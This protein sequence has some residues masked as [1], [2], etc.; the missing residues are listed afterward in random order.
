[1]LA[2][3][4]KDVLH[5]IAQAGRVAPKPQAKKDAV[6]S[7][8]WKGILILFGIALF[9]LGL[10]VSLFL[11]IMCITPVQITLPGAIIIAAVIIVLGLRRKP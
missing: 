7:D 8:T 9:I 4:L 6:Q 1:M 11:I 3:R 5:G 2:F 10:V